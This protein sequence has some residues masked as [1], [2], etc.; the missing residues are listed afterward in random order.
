MRHTISVLVKNQTGVLS[1]VSN[2]FSARGYNIDS[3]VV[4]ITDNPGV[5]RMTIV[6]KGDDRVIDQVEKQLNKLVD[7]IKVSDLTHEDFIARDLVLIKV[8]AEPATRSQVMEIVQCFDGKIVDVALKSFI[9]E[10]T[11]KESKINAMVELLKNYGVLEMVRTGEVAISR[12]KKVH[13]EEEK[14]VKIKAGK[15]GQ[16]NL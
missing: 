4:G 3:L 6:V 9:I 7:V 2:L 16:S 14:N 8:K 1:R 13:E 10:V 12:G 11:G 15:A 5:S